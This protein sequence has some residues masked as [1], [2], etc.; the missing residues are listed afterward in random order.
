MLIS[1]RQY[2][3]PVLSYYSDDI[4]N[5]YFSTN[6]NSSESLENY[7]FEAICDTDCKGIT[8]IINEK[9]AKYAF[10]IDCSSTRFRKLFSSYDPKFNFEIPSEKLE[11]K[12]EICSFVLASENMK[13]YFLEEFHEDYSGTVFSVNAGDILAIDRDRIFHAEKDIDSLQKI[14]SIFSVQPDYNDDAPHFDIDSSG[15][16]IIIKLSQSNYKN[17]SLIS[18]D[19][20]SNKLIASLFIIPALVQ[21]FETIKSNDSIDFEDLRW[22]HVIN[23]HLLKINIDMRMGDLENNSSILVAQEL[24]GNPIEEALNFLKIIVEEV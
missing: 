15:E 6:L 3:Y 1:Q 23:K 16:K 8:N 9:K 4:I 22:Y 12:V 14:P 20:N 2:P 21:T 18:L 24:I 7:S 11:G 19:H 17:Y 13:N 10:L 5:S